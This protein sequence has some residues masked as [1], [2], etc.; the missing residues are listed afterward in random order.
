MQEKILN[1]RIPKKLDDSL[2]KICAS[3]NISKSE[4]V[5]N[6][7]VEHFNKSQKQEE[8]VIEKLE[9]FKQDMNENLDKNIERIIKISTR[10]L[11]Y[12]ITNFHLLKLKIKNDLSENAT[13]EVK[14]K[15]VSI[16]VSEAKKLTNSHEVD[17]LIPKNNKTFFDNVI[18]K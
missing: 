14:D 18:E 12:G 6:I 15:T 1:V 9:K 7:L 8:K 5:R 11:L 4:Y 17:S 16:Y 13:S 2:N 3:S 10:N